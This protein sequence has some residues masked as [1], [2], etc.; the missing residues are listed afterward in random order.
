MKRQDRPLGPSNSGLSRRSQ[1]QV[2]EHRVV[3]QQD[4]RRRCLHL[5][6]ARSLVREAGLA[7][8]GRGSPLPPSLRSSA[9]LADVAPERDLGEAASSAEGA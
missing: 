5:A 9:C 2:L 7:G 3:R 6:R 4:V 1:Q 8:Y